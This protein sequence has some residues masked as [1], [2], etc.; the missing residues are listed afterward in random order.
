M[1]PPKVIQPLA[2]SKLSILRLGKVMTLDEKFEVI[3]KLFDGYIGDFVRLLEAIEP[4]QTKAEADRVLAEVGT[5]RW[6]ENIQTMEM[7]ES[8]VA[9]LFE[10]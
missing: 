9:K 6:L 3:G 1:K 5:D 2:P 4:C 10:K 7:L 8:K